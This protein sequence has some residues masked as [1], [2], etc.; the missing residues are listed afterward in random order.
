MVDIPAALL[1]LL[2]IAGWILI[3]ISGMVLRDILKEARFESKGFRWGILHLILPLL[4]LYPSFLF[5]QYLYDDIPLSKPIITALII[6]MT[7][8]CFLLLYL[9]Y[10]IRL[11]QLK[12]ELSGV[13]AALLV[14]YIGLSIYLSFQLGDFGDVLNNLLFTTALM[15]LSLSMFYLASYTISFERVVRVAPLLYAAGIVILMPGIANAFIL[16]NRLLNIFPHPIFLRV[17]GTAG[18]LLGGMLMFAAAD[19]F[20]RRV[21]EF[22]IKLK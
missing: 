20:R 19:K 17:T 15:M 10:Q 18:I 6:L 9:A 21:L 13:S 14:A 7:V 16:E 12:R 2:S 11:T 4:L 22:D 8:G 1:N 3:G 5:Y